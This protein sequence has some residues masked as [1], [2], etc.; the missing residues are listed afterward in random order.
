M[1]EVLLEVRDLVQTFRA[2]G[3]RRVQAVAGVDFDLDEGETLGL[4][5]ESGCGKTSLGRAILQLPPPSGGSVKLEGVELTGLSAGRMRQ[6]RRRLQMVFQDPVSSL[7]PRR[8]IGS[9]VVAPLQ[10]L[11]VATSERRR[12]VGAMLEAVGLDAEGVMGRYPH[13]LSGGQCQRVSIARALVLR[14]RLIVCDEPVSSLDVS[15]Q[16]QILNLLE[17]TKAQ[18]GLTLLFIAHDLAVVRRV[19]DR[20]AV[21]Y[22]GRLCEIAPSDQLVDSP[23]HPYTASLLAAVPRLHG[24]RRHDTGMAGGEIPS[25]LN[26]PSGCRFR[27]RCPLASQ[28]CA[29]EEPR[30]RELQPGHWVACHHAG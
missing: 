22:L 26:P 16:A 4:V 21:M 27:T 29:R 18:F 13:E 1:S 14:P 28:R 20:I 24:A 7:N 10:V 11:G 17:D 25:P 30:M 19:S 5:G 2:A 8:T 3:G 15:V 12:R 9:S 6:Q 23:L